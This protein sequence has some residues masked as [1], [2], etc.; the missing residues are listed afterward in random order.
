MNE[1][2]DGWI[3]FSATLGVAVIVRVFNAIWA[4]PVSHAGPPV[5]PEAPG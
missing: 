1:R 4:F 3:L 2:G 5:A